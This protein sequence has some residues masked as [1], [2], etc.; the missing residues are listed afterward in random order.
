[1]LE[2]LSLEQLDELQKREAEIKER[3]IALAAKKAAMLQKQENLS[4]LQAIASD[5]SKPLA[6]RVAAKI[7][8][9]DM[10]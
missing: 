4:E 7:K 9:C 2:Y 3:E 5:V 10:N 1:M 6:Q 8:I